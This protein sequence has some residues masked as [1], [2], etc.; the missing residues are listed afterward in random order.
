MRNDRHRPL[1]NFFSQDPY[2]S[3]DVFGAHTTVLMNVRF[4]E[5]EWPTD[6][7][8]ERSTHM[9]IRTADKRDVGCEHIH[10]RERVR[11]TSTDVPIVITHNSFGF[12]LPSTI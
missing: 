12:G 9:S 6:T 8:C 7:D 1:P 5:L 2:N 3:M 10:P 11:G 4:P